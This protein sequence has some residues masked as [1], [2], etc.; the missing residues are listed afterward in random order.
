MEQCAPTEGE[1][2]SAAV[3]QHL[4]LGATNALI[5]FGDVLTRYTASA[6]RTGSRE[7]PVSQLTA[8]QSDLE[9][10]GAVVTTHCL[11]TSHSG[12]GDAITMSISLKLRLASI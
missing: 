5:R 2:S 1:C 6:K 7:Q 9:E 12:V 8:P 11:P 10:V 4:R 3:Q